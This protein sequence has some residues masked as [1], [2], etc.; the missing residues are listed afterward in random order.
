MPVTHRTLD[1][2][3]KVALFVK[4]WNEASSP[5]EVRRVLGMSRNGV[6]TCQEWCKKHGLPIKRFRAPKVKRT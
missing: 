3:A 2:P 6:R 1:E 5:V 4:V